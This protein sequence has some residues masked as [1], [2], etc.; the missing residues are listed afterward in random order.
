MQ[1][2]LVATHED[3][4]QY[5]RIECVGQYHL[6]AY[7]INS[8]LAP[9][10]SRLRTLLDFGCG[11][12]KSTRAIAPSVCP[13]GKLI[14]TDISSDFLDTAV[15]LTHRAIAMSSTEGQG[16]L[17]VSEFEYVPTLVEQDDEHIA[18]EDDA[19][20]AVSTTIVLQEIQ[21]EMLLGKVLQEMGRVAKV[22][23]R[24]ALAV[25][26]DRITCEDFTSFTYSPFP[27][28]ATQIDNTRMCESTV[29]KIVWQKDRH[30]SKEIICEGLLRGGWSD[31][32]TV[33]P[34]APTFL[35][36]FPKNPSLPWKDETK[37]APLMLI[38]G[39]KVG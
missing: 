35:K 25:V 23:A 9:F 1:K 3:V 36:P 34:L 17:H 28:N 15:A 11:A 14:G 31:L 8:A 22:G 7:L 30:W 18:L 2:R 10:R 19:V 24:L 5:S 16:L 4:E 29:S 21:S 6:A 39:G 33:Y 13:G 27:Q 12:G 20:D 38:T 37:V 26:S 32:V